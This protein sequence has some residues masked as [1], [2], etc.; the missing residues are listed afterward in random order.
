MLL[1]VES[2]GP[3]FCFLSFV[4]W[5]L[6]FRF[7]FSYKMSVLVWL[8]GLDNWNH[9]HAVAVLYSFIR[10]SFYGFVEVQGF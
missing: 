2:Q 7:V 4:F 6:E 10:C 8:Y 1:F 5:S 9:W 3:R